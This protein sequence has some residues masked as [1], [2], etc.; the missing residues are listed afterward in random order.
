[1]SLKLVRVYPNTNLKKLENISAVIGNFD[2]FHK[3]H[4][5]LINQLKIEPGNKKAL[6]SFY[7]H[8][9]EFFTGSKY[10]YINSLKDRIA[11]LND[12]KFDYLFLIKFNKEFSSLTAENFIKEYLIKKLKINFLITGSDFKF[13]FKQ[14]GDSL[15]LEELSLKYNYKYESIDIKSLNS[16]KISSTNIKQDIK[17][18]NF[19]DCRTKLGR[20]FQIAGKVIKGDQRGREIGFKTANID[21]KNYVLPKLGVYITKVKLKGKLYNSISNI[22]IRPSFSGDNK[23]VLETHIFDYLG[24]DFYNEDISVIFLK[25]LRDE[26]KFNSINELILQIEIDIKKAKKFHDKQEI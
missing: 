25:F 22:G 17:N 3:G 15:L 20:D 23:V 8:T 6:I 10:K 12:L 18:G 4:I 16:S 2:A 5:S 7:P 9:K 21:P 11:I 19:K 14:Q 13:G 24:K 26:T 1:M